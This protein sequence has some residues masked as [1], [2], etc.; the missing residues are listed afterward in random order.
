MKDTY[1]RNDVIDLIA[2]CFDRAEIEKEIKA[3][4]AREVSLSD[5]GMDTL[6]LLRDAVNGQRQ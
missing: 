1:S 2:S 6:S 3:M 4:S 5:V